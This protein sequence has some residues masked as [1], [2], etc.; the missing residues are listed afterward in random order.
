[1]VVFDS[2]TLLLLLRPGKVGVPIDYH[3]GKPVQYAHE[4]IETLIEKLEEEKSKIIIPTPV[5]SE[6]LVHA[7]DEIGS[8]LD[9]IQKRAVF[10]VEPFD[11]IAAIEVA[12]MARQDHDNRKN[13]QDK[14]VTL[15]KI[16]YDRQIIAIA[17]VH[18]A[19][20]IYSDDE[21]IHAR[22]IGMN[23][24]AIRL[25]D[26]PVSQSKQQTPLDFNA[27]IGISF[28]GEEKGLINQPTAQQINSDDNQEET[29]NGEKI[30]NERN[31]KEAIRYKDR[32]IGITA[33]TLKRNIEL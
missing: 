19:S 30:E 32:K 9:V 3:T 17:K 10:S 31:Q 11:Q 18:G 1:M 20:T 33:G 28:L 4:R 24:E 29:G 25:A 22:V 13:R 12:F 21:H 2:T 27:P 8:I 16:K 5:I 23:I 14:N 6:L 15:A 26:L 7:G